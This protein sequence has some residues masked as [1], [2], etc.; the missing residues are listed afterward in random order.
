MLP[1][2]LCLSAQHSASVYCDKWTTRQ[3]QELLIF[4]T[5]KIQWTKIMML[6]NLVNP[7]AGKTATSVTTPRW[8]CYCWDNLRWTWV[9]GPNGGLLIPC[10]SY[11]KLHIPFQIF[12]KIWKRFK[13]LKFQYSNVLLLLLV[14]QYSII[15]WGSSLFPTFFV[16]HACYDIHWY[17]VYWVFIKTHNFCLIFYSFFWKIFK[18]TQWNLLCLLF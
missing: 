15:A 7:L 4:D 1:L 12:S 11:K 17:A 8:I 6:L 3:V 2:C 10:C 5:K 9:A 18:N 14:L 13:D 16:R